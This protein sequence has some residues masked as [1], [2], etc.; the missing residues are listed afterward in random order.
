M[1]SFRIGDWVVNT[2]E[3]IDFN[4]CL[5]LSIRLSVVGVS[6]VVVVVVVDVEV[7]ISSNDKPALLRFDVSPLE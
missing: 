4:C 3:D 7:F 2:E 6:V 1:C 5:R